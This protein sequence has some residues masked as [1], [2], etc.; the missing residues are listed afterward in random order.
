MFIYQ[1]FQ[2]YKKKVFIKKL[3]KIRP[4]CENGAGSSIA[5]RRMQAPMH[6]AAIAMA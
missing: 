6:A 3:Y 4:A 2:E 5:S 1:K